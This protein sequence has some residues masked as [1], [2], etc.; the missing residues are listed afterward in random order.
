MKLEDR[1][2]LLNELDEELLKGGVI[3]SE[4]CS[5]IVR[6]ADMA[7]VNG[8]HLASIL[9]AVSG[10]ETYLRSDYFESKKGRLFKLIDE[11]PIDSELKKDLHKLRK[12]RNKWVHVGEPWEDQA[13]IEDPDRFESELAEMA[14]FAA[15][16]LR[17]TIYENQWI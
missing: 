1:C 12:Y 10:I 4:W 17:R 7:F 3:M 8:S 2:L 14:Y 13:L 15:R 6:E 11:S 16:C 5:F 9:T